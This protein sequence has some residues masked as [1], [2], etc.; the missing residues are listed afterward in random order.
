MNDLILIIDGN[1]LMYRAFYAMPQLNNKQGIMTNAVFGFMSMFLKLIEDNKPHYVAVAFDMKG[2]TFR[3]KEYGEYKAT[4]QLTPEGLGQQFDLLMQLLDILPVNYYRYEGYE[5][6]DILGWLSSEA[7]KKGVKSLI[8]T[9]DRDALQLVS[10]SATVLLTKK[11]ISQIRLFDMEE[12]KNE[13]G[14]EPWQIIELKA[15]MGDSSD[16]IPGVMGIGEKT[17]LSL[18][19]QFRSLQGIYDNFHLV[20][21]T[22][23]RENLI[24][25][26]DKAYLSK[27]LATILRE[28]PFPVSFE[29]NLYKPKNSN[30]LKQ[31][32]EWLGFQSMLNKFGFSEVEKESL[33]EVQPDNDTV[34]I[35][36]EE[37]LSKLTMDL[38]GV[39]CLAIAFG[40]KLSIARDESLVYDILLDESSALRI[41]KPLF[42]S[43][44]ISKYTFD[45]KMLMHK[46]RNLGVEI[47]KIDFDAL[48]A[49]YLLNPQALRYTLTGIIFEYL[50]KDKQFPDATDL[51]V[52]T[53]FFKNK[54][55]EE[56]MLDL[57]RNI[58]HPLI[59]LLFRMEVNG[60]RIEKN[61]LTRLGIEFTETL[62]NTT[63]RIYKYAEEEFNINSPKQL[64]IVLFEKLML[65]AVKKTKTGFSTDIE[66]LEA[67]KGKHPVINEIIEHRQISKLNSTY[68]EGLSK[69]IDSKDG[70]IHSNFNQTIAVT[71]RISSTDPN[72]QNIPIR[73]E[74]G[75]KIRKVFIPS[76][77]CVLVDA[78]YSQIELRILAHMSGDPDFIQSF[79]S[80]EDIHRQTA[81]EIF[82]ISIDSVTSEQRGYAKAVNFGIIYGISDYG[83]SQNLGISVA[84]A[85]GYIDRY[86]HRYPRVKLYLDE[87]VENAQKTGYVSTL[88][89]R[90]R[91]IPEISSRNKTIQSQG[92]R[93]A[94][95]TPLQGT[96]AD[97]IKKAML[98]VDTEL[99][100]RNL[101]SRLI[102]QVHDELII[103]THKEEIEE[104][105]DLL[106][107][108]MANTV[109]LKV[110]LVVDV[111]VGDNWYDAK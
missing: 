10:E 24:K 47:K 25:E 76:E 64:G 27:R 51:I 87:L 67:L 103:D 53:E 78:D 97:I 12:L 46:C 70:K 99:R 16:N 28:S 40:G 63:E 107:N 108:K 95:N 42:E 93:L 55:F 58:E 43:E 82:D 45:A 98:D 9:G 5:A 89:G 50:G 49:A 84:S 77:N 109:T 68:I 94:M 6:D 7:T 11:G 102:L 71:G 20:K 69:M 60:F 66:V 37:E 13:Y 48:L 23:L 106:K 83:L 86:F 3:H 65:P 88:M 34:V 44:K 61:E 96:A 59:E 39:S 57:Y 52:L 33:V 81:A 90:K 101:K 73:L 74:M 104:V 21:G 111:G 100:L 18:I 26:K 75:R 2:P 56:G 62:K 14:M 31:M 92:K 22:K 15:L 105:K 79:L 1:S 91:Y 17:A 80:G 29:D 41:L 4:R 110:P 85:K 38:E 54:L 8:V 72:L 32:F 30:E 35:Q 36:T 19:H